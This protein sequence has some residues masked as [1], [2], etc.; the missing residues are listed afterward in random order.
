[1]TRLQTSRWKMSSLFPHLIG[2][3]TSGRAP[4]SE[5]QW[6]VVRLVETPPRH[7]ATPIENQLLATL[8]KTGPV[9]AATLVRRVAADLYAEELRQGAGVL[10][11]GLYGDR[12]FDHEIV[13]ELRAGDGVLWK[14]QRPDGV[15]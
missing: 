2:R 9:A 4:V 8:E 10:D 15:N 14:I 11:I 3:S 5:A 13:R 12:L 6:A 7:P 1:M